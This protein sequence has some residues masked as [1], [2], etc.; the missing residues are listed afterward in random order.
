V[1]VNK[2]VHLEQIAGVVGTDID[3]LRS[4]NPEYRRDVVPGQTKP[5]AIRMPLADAGKFIDLEDSVYNYRTT[6]FLTKRAVVDVADDLP[7]YSPRGRAYYGRKSGRYSRRSARNSRRASARS[8]RGSR[9]GGSSIT[10]KR[11]QTL[12]EIAKRNG[13]TVQK[14]RKLNGLKGNNIVAGKKLRVK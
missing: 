3:M 9:G 11:G 1:V 13:T 4:L 6:E 8:G 12:S 14:L 2:N 10:I 7:T 5:S